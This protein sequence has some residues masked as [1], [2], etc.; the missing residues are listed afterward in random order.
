VSLITTN[1]SGNFISSTFY[2]FL[3]TPTKANQVLTSDE[4][5]RA[6]WIDQPYIPERL[7]DL[8]NDLG[9]V[10]TIDGQNVLN[11]TT[12]TD[13]ALNNGSYSITDGNNIIFTGRTSA[14][15]ITL[16][17]DTE[18]PIGEYDFNINILSAANKI[19]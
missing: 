15:S 6:E 13:T 19:E 9:F 5:K 10:G 2:Q 12:V 4:N 11:L 14:D 1:A 17:L 7:S 18:I 16:N 3:K 8:V